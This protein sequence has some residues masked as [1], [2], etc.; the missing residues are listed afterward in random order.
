MQQAFESEIYSKLNSLSAGLKSEQTLGEQV[1]ELREL[2]ATI[3]ERLQASEVALA[4]ARQHSHGLQAKEQL[5]QQRISDLEVETATLRAQPLESLLTVLRQKELEDKNTDLL[6][7]MARVR[8]EAREAAKLSQEQALV[9]AERDEQ[10]TG[11]NAQLDE[12]RATLTTLAVEKAAS[13]QRA[14]ERYDEFRNEVSKAANKEKANISNVHAN[15]LL[16]LKNQKEEADSRAGELLG[17]LTALKN[18]EVDKASTIY[19]IIPKLTKL[20]LIRVKHQV[21]SG[22]NVH[23]WKYRT[24]KKTHVLLLCKRRFVTLKPLNLQMQSSQPFPRPKVD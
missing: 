8:E 11:L 2:K 23:T 17:Q 16:Q 14:T 4:E 21:H 10:I 13:E 3:R 19:T 9:L 24:L 1:T 12:I 5:L 15:A 22:P 7:D 20:T 6:A 18:A